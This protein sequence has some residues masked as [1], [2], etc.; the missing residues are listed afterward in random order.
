M[1]KLSLHRVFSSMNLF[2]KV[3]GKH[4]EIA[5]SDCGLV[6]GGLLAIKRPRATHVSEFTDSIQE[7]TNDTCIY[8]SGGTVP[9]KRPKAT[10]ASIQFIITPPPLLNDSQG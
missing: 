2:I 7:L 3:N 6:A 8:V 4:K 10:A 9:N 1:N 5:K